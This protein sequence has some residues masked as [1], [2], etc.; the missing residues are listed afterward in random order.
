MIHMLIYVYPYLVL[1]TFEYLKGYQFHF[2]SPH[3]LL[4]APYLKLFYIIMWQ[5]LF[6]L[7]EYVAA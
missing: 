1:T 7:M 5:L 4:L 2:S 3:W 6:L